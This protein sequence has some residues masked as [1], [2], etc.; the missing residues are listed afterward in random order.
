MFLSPHA[1]KGFPVLRMN[2]PS[3]IVASGAHRQQFLQSYPFQA[4]PSRK[5]DPPSGGEKDESHY[6]ER[7]EIQSQP[8]MD[9]ILAAIASLTDQMKSMSAVLY[10]MREMSTKHSATLS[11]HAQ[12]IHHMAAHG[13]IQP[14]LNLPG[15]VVSQGS[16]RAPT[17]QTKGLFPL[18]PQAPQLFMLPRM[19]AI[20]QL[21]H[22]HPYLANPVHASASQGLHLDES[23]QIKRQE[24][25]DRRKPARQDVFS[26]LS[27]PRKA[28][29]RRDDSPPAITS[30]SNRSARSSS[31]Q[32]ISSQSRVRSNSL[33]NARSVTP[34]ASA[35]RGRSISAGP[36]RSVAAASRGR[37]VNASTA[38][39]KSPSVVRP[40]SSPV[41]RFEVHVTYGNQMV[42]KAA[43]SPCLTQDGPFLY[44][45]QSEL[46]PSLSFAA[47]QNSPCPF[48]G[49]S[50]SVVGTNTRS[51]RS[52]IVFKSHSSHV[53]NPPVNSADG[54]FS[55]SCWLSGPN[56]SVVGGVRVFYKPLDD[57]DSSISLYAMSLKYWFPEDT[58]NVVQQAP[59]FT[60][61]HWKE[62]VRLL[63][64]L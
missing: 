20:P 13:K 51:Q 52:N 17:P 11:A 62:L 59:N 63:G 10:D 45:I 49:L 56:A 48:T 6:R 33:G 9:P 36:T 16:T 37:M 4:L 14:S 7:S 43:L 61:D 27:Q 54:Y 1:W 38:R 2:P 41:I 18:L 19:P 23:P 35:S 28:L 15:D 24:P 55:H 39:S 58:E 47:P 3:D 29:V 21:A 8:Q 40:T 26:R 34:T 50:V 53:E 30:R 46:S 57:N 32:V 64:L 44:V 31:R 25:A 60:K 22:A 5:I 42:A 12:T